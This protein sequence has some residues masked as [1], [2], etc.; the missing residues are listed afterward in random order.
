VAP[1]ALARFVLQDDP[2]WTHERIE[3]AMSAGV[4]R[5]IRLRA[6]LPVLIAYSTVVVK[7]GQVYF[8]DDLYG[9]DMLLD[10]ALR[11]R[12]AALA[13]QPSLLGGG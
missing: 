2:H 12:S 11:A 10:Q 7:H 13:R 9:H 6:P 5:T 3:E 8:Y 4:S 1:V